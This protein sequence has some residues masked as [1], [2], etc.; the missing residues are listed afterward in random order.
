MDT[1]FYKLSIFF[2]NFC[3]S[4]TIMNRYIFSV[5]VTDLC[6]NLWEIIFISTPSKNKMLAWVYLISLKVI[7][8]KLWDFCYSVQKSDNPS[9]LNS[10]KTY[11]K[12]EGVKSKKYFNFLIKLSGRLT[13]LTL[14]RFFAINFSLPFDLVSCL[15]LVIDTVQFS[16]SKSFFVKA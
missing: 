8:F 14:E 11:W 15:V 6:P 3:F 16:K 12:N 9:I 5:V 13:F 4:S 2:D 7:I 10:S 1:Y